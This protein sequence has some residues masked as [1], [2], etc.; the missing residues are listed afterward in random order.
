MI[1]VVTCESHAGQRDCYS[2]SSSIVN[3]QSMTGKE[4]K[5]SEHCILCTQIL[6]PMLLLLPRHGR[7]VKYLMVPFFPWATLL[8]VEWIASAVLVV[9]SC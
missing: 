6:H 9:G 2:V 8:L 7:T 3:I 1:S 4:I 5:T